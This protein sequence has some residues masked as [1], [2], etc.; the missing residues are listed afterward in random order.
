MGQVAAHDHEL[1][2]GKG[3][4]EPDTATVTKSDA[5]SKD[6]ITVHNPQTG[7]MLCGNRAPMRRNLQAY[8]ASHPGWE[9]AAAQAHSPSHNPNPAPKLDTSVNTLALAL[10]LTLHGGC[11]ER[12][13]S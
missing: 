10:T 9:V 7:K 1:A 3:E 13:R 5:S 6:R 4:E 8:L 2:E 11:A 12:C